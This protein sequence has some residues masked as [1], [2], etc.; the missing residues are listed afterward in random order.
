MRCSGHSCVHVYNIHHAC[1]VCVVC[2]HVGACV[3]VCVCMHVRMC[4]VFNM[5]AT[6]CVCMCHLALDDQGISRWAF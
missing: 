5:P 3:H 4:V 1:H 2:L 6:M